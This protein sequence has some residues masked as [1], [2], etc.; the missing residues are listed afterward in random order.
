MR[1]QGLSVFFLEWFLVGKCFSKTKMAATWSSPEDIASKLFWTSR[2][3]TANGTPH[4]EEIEI[5]LLAGEFDQAS[6]VRFFERVVLIKSDTTKFNIPEIE[7]EEMEGTARFTHLGA[8]LSEM[9]DKIDGAASMF[10]GP[11][12]LKIL[13]VGVRLQDIVEGCIPLD[14]ITLVFRDPTC[15][16]D[17]Y[18]ESDPAETTNCPAIYDHCVTKKSFPLSW[19]DKQELG[20]AM[21]AEPKFCN[22]EAIEKLARL[23]CTVRNV[24]LLTG[25]GVS[26]ES[27]VPAYRGTVVSGENVWDKYD[28]AD[29][30]I[31]NFS[32]DSGARQRYWQRSADLTP[33]F[34]AA[35]ANPAHYLAAV[36]E[37][38]GRLGRVITTNID[39]LY[40]QAGV[41]AEKTIY[42]HGVGHI[43]RCLARCSQSC[44]FETAAIVSR[45]AQQ[46]YD[47]LCEY[48]GAPLKPAT[49]SFGQPLE[50][51]I[52][53]NSE[54]AAELAA[55]D[56]LLVMGSSLTVAPS[57]QLPGFALNANVPLALFNLDPTQFDDFATFHIGHML[58]GQASKVIIDRLTSFDQAMASQE[59]TELPAFSDLNLHFGCF[60]YCQ[61]NVFVPTAADART[62][63]KIQAFS[64]DELRQ[65]PS[66]FPHLQRW[67]THIA[68]FSQEERDSW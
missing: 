13:Q 9:K 19:N 41:S 8:F 47:P 7:F 32:A 27:G 46:P 21:P 38:T 53:E 33:Y 43:T 39:S 35:N 63:N 10:R 50:I 42:L 52:D 29:E 49:I 66:S 51:P 64:V 3:T 37:Q 45:F 48:C 59:Q 18:V 15:R 2:E 36:L 6:I 12:A 60:S 1:L 25:A 34:Q 11:G 17:V 5:R 20:L 28:P 4:G 26:T 22:D 23:L 61:P 16:T 68:S 24:T 62:F 56:A 67:I 30:F 31:E 55:S 57:N 40:A 65:V 44:D 54:I 14:R 58:C